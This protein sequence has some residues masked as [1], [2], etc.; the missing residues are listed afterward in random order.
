ME[1]SGPVPNRP[2]QPP[3]PS[4]GSLIRPEQVR[5][6]P[7]L[8]EQQKAQQEANITKLWE[9]I[10]KTVPGTAEQAK[11]Y[12]QLGKVSAFLMQGMR[13]HQAAVKL[14]MQQRA[15]QAGQQNGA[16]QNQQHPAQFEGLHPTI[17]QKVN[18]TRFIFPPQMVEGT[19]AA[20]NWLREAK[21]RYGQA[22]QRS[23]NARMKQGEIQR[24][25]QM[26]E[27]SGQA[28]SPEEKVSIGSKMG[29]CKKAIEES[30]VFMTKFKEQQM[31][32]QRAR[33]PQQG[34]QRFSNHGPTNLD[35]DPP[36]MANVAQNTASQGGPNAH[37]ISSAVAAARDQASAAQ[38]GTSPTNDQ[39]QISQNS[40]AMNATPVNNRP[41][42]ANGPSP[43]SA[44]LGNMASINMGTGNMSAP[45]SATQPG[46]PRSFSQQGNLAQSAQTHAGLQPQSQ[47][48]AHPQNY[49]N[50]AKRDDRQPISKNLQVSEPKPV[51][52][53]PARPTMNGGPGVGMPGQ[54]AQP[55]IP[56]M[57][58]YVLETS[59]DGRVLSK[60]RLNELAR[61]VCGP[62][63]DG[64]LTP[65]VE[66]VS[67]YA[68]FPVWHSR[69]LLISTD[70]PLR[71]G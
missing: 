54:M 70:P 9:G 66:E 50:A 59:E 65:E 40:A 71:H 49:L 4:Q 26:R 18:Q 8:S 42:S 46:P 15:N 13:N 53:P 16:V 24:M 14:Q 17:Q 10:N 63:P 39:A 35:G 67:E 58:G 69:P 51:P 23:E 34:Q 11:Y 41:S 2:P 30:Q 21:G 27:A 33:E 45:G 61:E 60:K 43:Y 57:P 37:S 55:A 38:S 56:S 19:Q 52:V 48:H 6:L 12:E 22:L 1:G 64:Q 29:Q 28:L 47:A 3:A 44:Q 5:K 7:Q 25:V 62:G 31:Q 32:F 36:M 20:E 68:L